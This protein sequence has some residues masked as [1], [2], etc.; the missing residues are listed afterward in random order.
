MT[1]R[2]RY[3]AMLCKRHADFQLNVVLSRDTCWQFPSAD[4][5]LSYGEDLRG[6]LG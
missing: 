2:S 4:G 6:Q 5:A 1:R 3:E